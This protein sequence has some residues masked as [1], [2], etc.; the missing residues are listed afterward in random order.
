MPR[1]EQNALKRR[2]QQFHIALD[3]IDRHSQI[4]RH[5]AD[6]EQVGGAAE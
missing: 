1:G 2:G 5:L 6:G 4:P 3:G